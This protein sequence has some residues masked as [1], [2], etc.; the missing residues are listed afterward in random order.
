[1]GDGHVCKGSCP[2]LP[3]LVHMRLKMLIIIMEKHM[4]TYGLLHKRSADSLYNDDSISYRNENDN[5]DDG[6]YDDDHDNTH[7]LYISIA[8]ID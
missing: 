5:D 6:D 2:V 8:M 4:G 3:K 7:V 1:M